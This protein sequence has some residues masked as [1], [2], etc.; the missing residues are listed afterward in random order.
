MLTSIS[1]V[2]VDL[3]APDKEG[4]KDEV[5]EAVLRV[6]DLPE[7]VTEAP[8]ITEIGTDLIPVIEVGL[9][10]ELRSAQLREQA[11]KF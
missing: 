11:A 8:L 10:G 1:T 3:Q 9:A 5:R 7:A 4:T 6:T 2:S